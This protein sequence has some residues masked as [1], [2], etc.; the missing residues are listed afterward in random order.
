MC[1]SPTQ[2]QNGGNDTNGKKCTHHPESC[3]GTQQIHIFAIYQYGRGNG[4][5]D[6]LFMPVWYTCVHIFVCMRACVCVWL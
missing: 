2:G 5:V 3:T 4:C 6:V 1:E